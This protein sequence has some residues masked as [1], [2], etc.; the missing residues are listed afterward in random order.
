MKRRPEMTPYVLDNIQPIPETGCWLYLGW[1]DR[2][3]YAVINKHGE[4]FF[5]HR[6]FYEHFKHLISDDLH[7]CHKCDT[8]PCVN[9]DHMFLGT[10]FDNMSDSGRKGRLSNRPQ[11]RRRKP[12]AAA[13]ADRRDGE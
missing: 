1:W 11:N 8:P 4:T 10:R 12:D 3:K 6:A 9:P 7:V 2:Q 13:S 5:A